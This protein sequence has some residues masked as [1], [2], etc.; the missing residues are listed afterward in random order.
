VGELGGGVETLGLGVDV[1]TPSGDG[2]PPQEHA[3]TA[4]A[5]NAKIAAG[6]R[7]VERIVII[8]DRCG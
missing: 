4:I 6:F 8:I 3:D 5:M 7:V 2:D 1:G